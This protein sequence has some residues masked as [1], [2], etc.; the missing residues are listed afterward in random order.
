MRQHPNNDNITEIFI[1]LA[2][3][4]IIQKP[5]YITERWSAILQPL[6]DILT[7]SIDEIYLKLEPTTRKVLQLIQDEPTS[8][9]REVLGY[10]KRFV[11][12]LEVTQLKRFLVFT[13]RVAM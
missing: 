7:N 2:H 6:K 10:L 8:S 3:K 5:N 9:E 12:S 1:K 13:A 4:E 11:R